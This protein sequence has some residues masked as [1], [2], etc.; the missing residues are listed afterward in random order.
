MK[1]INGLTI[2][3][4]LLI[5]TISSSIGIAIVNVNNENQKLNQHKIYANNLNELLNGF[6]Q[7]FDINGYKTTEWNDLKWDNKTINNL[8]QKELQGI[9]SICGKGTWIPKNGENSLK[10]VKCNLF[11]KSKYDINMNVYMHES[12]GN[13]TNVILDLNLKTIESFKKNY[14]TIESIINILKTKISQKS[15]GNVEIK[16]I[17]ETTNTI[18]SGSECRTLK[19]NCVYR[20]NFDLKHNNNYLKTNGSNSI[21]K[22]NISFKE[23]ENKS[24]LKCSYW[25]KDSAGNWNIYTNKNCGIGIYENNLNYEVNVLADN[26]YFEKINLNKKCNIFENSSVDLPTEKESLCGISKDNL[27]IVMLST[28][29]HVNI[30]N[31][32][33]VLTKEVFANKVNLKNEKI[34]A[35]NLIAENTDVIRIN[36]EKIIAKKINVLSDKVYFKK[37]N[38]LQ[39]FDVDTL[40]IKNINSNGINQIKIIETNE[41]NINNAILGELNRNKNMTIDIIN[42]YN[43]KSDNKLSSPI[44]NFQNINRK[45][46]N[47]TDKLID[48]DFEIEEIRNKKVW[49]FYRRTISTGCHDGNTGNYEMLKNGSNCLVLNKVE[50]ASIRKFGDRCSLGAGG[51]SGGG[52]SGYFGYSDEI[53]NYSICYY[54]YK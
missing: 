41:A 32:K 22:N 36:A 43:I 24:E 4:A 20:I 31:V 11:Y 27:K 2:I 3:E 9:N 25:N 8:V 46:V 7:K 48:F 40:N 15:S 30:Y 38:D 47:L 18:I 21:I 42:S 12:S 29:T 39:I 13:I 37:D 28:K 53:S 33:D 14:K 34:S 19:N 52:T 16:K 49:K 50:L 54:K 45:I 44:G 10:L 51:A 35:T 1:K 17:N 23:E 5:I 6:D 26:L